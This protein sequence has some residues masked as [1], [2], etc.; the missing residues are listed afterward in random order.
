W[1][2]IVARPIRSAKAKL[3]LW[4]QRQTSPDRF[5]RSWL[6]SGASMPQTLDRCAAGSRARSG[7]ALSMSTSALAL[8]GFAK[9]LEGR[10]P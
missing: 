10:K 4:P 7:Y 3:A 8:R 9:P 6:L 2:M 1:Q 5:A